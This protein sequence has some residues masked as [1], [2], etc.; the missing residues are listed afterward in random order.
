MKSTM[1][2]QPLLVDDILKHA[3]RYYADVEIVSNMPDKSRHRTTYGQFAD[4]AT[5]LAQAL[6]EAG[7]KR[8]DRVATLCWNHHV[9]LEAYFGI[10]AANGVLHICGWPPRTSPGSSITPRTAFSSWTTSCCRSTRSSRIR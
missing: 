10:P 2:T 4:R 3:G 6:T 7:L 5:R 9:H 1:M 8:E